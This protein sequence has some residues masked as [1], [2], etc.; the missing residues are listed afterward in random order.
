[1]W[2]MPILSTLNSYYKLGL[3]GSGF[4]NLLRNSLL[5]GSVVKVYQIYHRLG[6]RCAVLAAIL[7][8]VLTKMLKLYWLSIFS[9]CSDNATL[10]PFVVYRALKE[11]VI[12]L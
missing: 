5:Y 12:F 7:A 3:S 6:I 11:V 4:E 1:M 9:Y 8:S 10:L 2:I